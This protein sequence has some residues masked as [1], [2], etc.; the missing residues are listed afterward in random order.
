MFVKLMK[1][2]LII[3]SII[4]ISLLITL[5]IIGISRM[6]WFFVRVYNNVYYKIN[7]STP[8]YPIKSVKSN[9]EDIVFLEELR[10]HGN[11]KLRILI[12]SDGH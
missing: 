2:I 1:V 3:I 4:L 7:S 5:N 10:K 8:S 9:E 6:S 11:I 12:A